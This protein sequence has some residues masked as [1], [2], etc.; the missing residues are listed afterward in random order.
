MADLRFRHG[1]GFPQAPVPPPLAIAGIL[2]FNAGKSNMYNKDAN[3]ENMTA[4]DRRDAKLEEIRFTPDTD[5]YFVRGRI[6]GR[7][8]PRPFFT[9]WIS[10]H[11]PERIYSLRRFMD[12]GSARLAY[13]KNCAEQKLSGHRSL[14][15]DWQ[16]QRVYEWEGLFVYPLGEKIDEKQARAMIARI[17]RAEGIPRPKLFWEKHTDNSWVFPDDNELHFGHRDTVGLLHELAHLVHEGRRDPEQ[18][19]AVH[20]PTFVWTAIELYHR[21]G[22]IDLSYLIRSAAKSGLLGDVAEFKMPED[23]ARKQHGPQR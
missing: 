3:R 1:Q 9:G 19:L 12:R 4:L 22:G 21:H 16:Q 14:T 15:R 17:C 11:R 6:P 7:G 10:R 8:S 2:R 13:E 18:P 23:K 20:G 5:S